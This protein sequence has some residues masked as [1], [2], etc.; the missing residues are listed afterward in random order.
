MWCQFPLGVELGSRSGCGTREEG[1]RKTWRRR[2]SP[3]Q[4][5]A[6]RSC[7]KTLFLWNSDWRQWHRPWG[8]PEHEG[9]RG[10][11]CSFRVLHCW[12]CVSLC[13][14]AT[15]TDPAHLFEV[16]QIERKINM[17][18]SVV[19]Y[20]TRKGEETETRP[21]ILHSRPL[22]RETNNRQRPTK[23]NNNNK[24]KRIIINK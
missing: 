24:S 18:L 16:K 11:S 21:G 5:L 8:L 9:W 23:K 14:L 1:R 13:R 22:F 7:E 3:E 12:C 20:R 10:W 6:Q 4:R 15:I 19:K 17:S 2:A